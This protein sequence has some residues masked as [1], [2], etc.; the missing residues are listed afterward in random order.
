MHII[1]KTSGGDSQIGAEGSA[2]VMTMPSSKS[3]IGATNAPAKPPR[4]EGI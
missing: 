4:R 2:A 3:G 1:T